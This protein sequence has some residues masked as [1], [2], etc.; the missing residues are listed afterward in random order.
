MVT[1]SEYIDF[2]QVIE[3]KHGGGLLVVDQYDVAM[4]EPE[5]GF[6]IDSDKAEVVILAEKG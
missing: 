1:L 6:G 2:L 5:V 4:P 3:A